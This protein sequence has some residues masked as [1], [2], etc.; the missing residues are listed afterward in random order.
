M[1]ASRWTWG[2]L[3]YLHWVSRMQSKSLMAH[4]CVHLFRAIQFKLYPICS[5]SFKHA[6]HPAEMT[7]ELI[8]AALR[9]RE[10]PLRQLEFPRLFLEPL[11]C[12]QHRPP[13][14]RLRSKLGHRRVVFC[15]GGGFPQ[16]LV[17]NETPPARE[18]NKSRLHLHVRIEDESLRVG[19][20]LLARVSICSS[21]E[22]S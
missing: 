18:S 17:P 15:R 7:I 21:I 13:V 5:P 2:A 1:G 12:H 8:F 9:F 10:R 20:A 19:R 22:W 4:C 3:R 14:V 16:L 11:G 6:A